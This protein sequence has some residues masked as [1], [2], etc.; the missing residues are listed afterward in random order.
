VSPPRDPTVFVHPQALCESDAVGP[1]TR[2]WAFAHVMA[3]ARI[4]ADCNLGDHA[5]IES[6]AVLGD[7]VIVKNG[8]LVWDKV[9]IEDEVFLGPGAVFTNDLW[10]NVAH[11]NPPEAFL[12][13]R[14]CRGATVGANATVVCGIT[15]G[16]HAFVGAG[17]V[18]LHDVPAHALVVGVPARPIGWVCACTKRLPRSLRCACGRRWRRARGNAGLVAADPPDGARLTRGAAGRRRAARP[19]RRARRR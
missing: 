2:V 3:G 5:F 13:T 16:A 17:S 11:K 10:P 8:V 14:V 12:P 19:R 15:V 9:T 1:R 4:G 7:R 6:G 18:V